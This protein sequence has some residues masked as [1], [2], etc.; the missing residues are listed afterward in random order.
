VFEFGSCKTFDEEAYKK[1]REKPCSYPDNI[2]HFFYAG[3][4]PA[5]EK[6]NFESLRW[7]YDS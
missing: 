4:H 2:N 1:C 3:R 7:V 6:Q 5:G